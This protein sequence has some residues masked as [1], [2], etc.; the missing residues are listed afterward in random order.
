MSSTDRKYTADFYCLTQNGNR[1]NTF[2]KDF[3]TSHI[4]GH[5][6]AV[7]LEKGDTEKYQIRSIELTKCGKIFKAVFGRCKYGETPEQTSTDGNESDV[8]LKPDHGLVQKNH[9]LYFAELNLIVYQRNSSGSRYS[10][11]QR[12]F[13]IPNFLGINLEPV[14]TG[15]SYTRIMKGGALKK[16]EVSILKPTFPLDSGEQFIQE[17]INIFKTSDAGSVK[18]SVS[19]DRG[20]KLSEVMR[21]SVTTLARFGRTRIARVHLWDDNDEMEVVD[22]IGDRIKQPF[23]APLGLNGR[24]TAQDVYTGLAKAKDDRSKDLEAFFG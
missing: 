19:A 7:N 12:Y 15:D 16:I 4:G 3:L 22:L 17:A 9:F 2:L 24:P 21:S 1:K 6:P 13:N 20:K 5:G 11:L 10:K 23:S 8:Q 18:V 14:L